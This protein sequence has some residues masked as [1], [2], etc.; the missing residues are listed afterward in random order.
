MAPESRESRPSSILG[1]LETVLYYT[2]HEQTRRF[3][4]DVLGMVLMESDPARHMFF[5]A[6]RS[7]FLLFDAGASSIEGKLP[8]HGAHGS[9]HTCFQVPRDTYEAWKDYL[10]GLGV[11]ILTEMQWTRGRSFYFHDPDDNLLEIADADIWP[12][13]NEDGGEK[14]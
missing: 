10:T 9:V 14:S 2:D 11:P 6:G 8:P 5:R 7:V 12:T 1:V 4:R 3:Y 13:T